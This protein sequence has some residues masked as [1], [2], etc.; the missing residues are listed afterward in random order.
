MGATLITSNAV[1]VEELKEIELP[2][3]TDSYQ[4][5][6][7]VDFI[8]NVK[9]IASKML[10]T[11]SLDSERYGT[12]REGNQ[13]FGTMTFKNIAEEGMTL[14]EMTDDIGLSIGIRNSY[15]KSMSLGLAVGATVFVCENL[16]I[17]GEVTVMRKHQGAILDELSTLIFKALNDAENKFT[18]LH[19]DSQ[20][21]KDIYI[22]NNDAYSMM[23]RLYG[24]GVISERQLPVVKNE[25]KKPSHEVFNTGTAWTLYNA[26]T[27][28]L[29]KTAPMHRMNKQI[30][31]H[32]TFSKAYSLN[33]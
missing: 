28:A 8:D 30:M 21:M 10:P 3:K 19:A 32:N 29:K 26:G 1:T 5:V 11:R 12:A 24:H 14:S 18:T 15:D 23:G 4:P 9:S 20:A 13:L 25:W 33:G 31:L 16:M 27:E 2:E 22:S 17:T 6:S 7:H